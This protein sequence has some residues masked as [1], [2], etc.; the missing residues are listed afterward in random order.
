MAGV[1][2]ML[3][4]TLGENRF[5]VLSA[6]A[7]QVEPVSGRAI[8]G[9]L[10]VSPTTASDHLSLLEAAGLVR[11]STVGRAKLWGLD[12]DCDLVRAWLREAGGEVAS[13]A[14]S[15]GAGVTFERKVVADYLGRL[16]AGDTAAGLGSSRVVVSVALQQAPEFTVDD[17]VVR[18]ALE[19]EAE[20]S[21]VLALAARRTPLLQT[22]N[23]KSQKLFKGLV[24]QL[25]LAEPDGPELRLGLAV[26]GAQEHTE[27][28]KV[29]VGAAAGQSGATGFFTLVRTAG[30][31][32][33]EVQ[34]RLKQIEGLVEKALVDLGQQN[35]PTD[36]V[37]Q[38]TWE[39][40]RRLVVLSP[41]M[42]GPDDS[43]WAALPRVLRPFSTQGTLY[44]GTL[45]RDRLLTLAD[46][47]AP[48]AALVDV[49]M[50]RRRVHELL[51]SEAGRHAAGWRALELLAEQARDAVGD[52][53]VSVDR[54]RRVRLDRSD[55]VEALT[56]SA[57]GSAG[58]VLH[59]ESGV[60]KSAVALRLV[61]A[62][63]KDAG[64]AAAEGG[65][66]VQAAAV[67]VVC[68][69]LRHLPGT[70]LEFEAL[71]GVPLKGL[72]AE[73]SA[74]T[75]L[76][77]VDGADAVGEGRQ[78]LLTYVVNAAVTADVHVVAVT[79]SDVKQLVVD[80]LTGSVG[81]G[82]VEVAVPP[83][84]DAQVDVVVAEL[85]E[86]EAMAANP[87]SRELLRRPVL[88]DLL[89]R[90]GVEGVP[91]SDFDAMEQVWAGLVR[92]R[93]AS[94]R[95][96]PGA[97]NLVML[98]LAR[99]VLDGR[100]QLDAA[101]T[102]DPD[103]VEGLR[104]DGLLRTPQDNPYRPAPEF[105][106][107]ELRRYAVA[108]LLLA[109]DVIK[110]LVDAGV[111]RWALG[112]ARLACQAMLVAG[113]TPG[114]PAAGRFMRWQGRFN[115]LVGAG[116]GERWADVPGEALLTLGDPRA[117]LRDAWPQLRADD[118]A[119]VQRLVRLVDQRLRDESKFVR[120]APVE[121]L[122]ESLLEDETPWAS[123]KPE[124]TLLMDWLRSLATSQTPSGY[125]LREQLRGLLVD[126]CAVADE[127]LRVADEEREAERA[128][129]AAAMTD[130]E[131]AEREARFKK[132]PRSLFQEIGYPRGRPRRERPAISREIT[133]ETVVELFALLGA[134]LGADGEALLRRVAE[135][136]PEDLKPAMEGVTCGHALGRYRQGFLTEMVLAYYLDEE[137]D[138]QGGHINDEGVRDHNF[139]G[140]GVPH[141]ASWRGP[142]M[143]LFEND[144]VGGI[145]ALNR[146]LNHAAL[147]RART[148]AS[149]YGYYGPVEDS[150]LDQ[151]RTELTITG[152]PHAYVGDG[153]VW[154][155]YRGT[156]VGPYPCMSALQALER[157]CDHIIGLG[158]PL[159]RLVSMLLDGCDNVAMVALVVGLLVRHLDK[160]GKLLDRFLAEPDVWH[161]EF[162]RIT[163]DHGFF[164]A[165]SDGIVHAE[166]QQW[167]LREAAMSLV[168][169]AGP[170]RAEELRS[171]G[172]QLVDR[173]RQRI[174]Q[175]GDAV[176]AQAANMELN[177]VRG[178]AS[179]LDRATYSTTETDEGWVI[180]SN[181]PA[182]V[183][184][185]LSEGLGWVRRSQEAMRLT[186]RYHVN[187]EDRTAE[188]VTTEA[189]VADLD[190]AAALM[191][192]PQGLDE[193]DVDGVAAVALVALEEH[194]GHGL[195]L[196]DASVKIAAD[197]VLGIGE[198]DPP[199]RDHD[200]EE[201]YF[202][203]GA[204]RSAAR[205]LPLLLTPAADHV[206]RV[207]DGADGTAAYTRIEAALAALAASNVIQ[208]RLFIARGLDHVWAAPCTNDAACVHQTAL[209][210]ATDMM[211][212]CV[213]GPWS[214]E[215]QEHS[216]EVL[217]D[218][219]VDTLPA[220]AGEDIY[221]SRLDPAIRALGQAA[222]TDTCVAAE[223]SA[224]LGVL[225][226]AQR[227]ALLA[228]DRDTD[229]RGTHALA[230]ARALLTVNDDAAILAHVDAYVDNPAG[231]HHTLS[232]ISA[233]AEEGPRRA[234][235]AHRI[236]PTIVEH[237][238]DAHDSGH[239]PF[240]RDDRDWTM[241]ALL[242]A[243]AGEGSYL[244]AEHAG[245]PIAWWDPAAAHTTVER[246]LG[247]AAGKPK[248]V[249]RLVRF[250]AS[251]LPADEQVRVGLPWVWRAVLADPA[252]VANRCYTVAPWLIEIRTA[253]QAAGALNSWQRTVDALVVAGDSRLAPYS[254]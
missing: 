245:K 15:G 38:W 166:R 99:Q 37:E 66:D 1:A 110:R 231:L 105:A 143:A 83:L 145:A 125:A 50:V 22:S 100:D 150:D 199:L 96:T 207:V 6:V 49:S 59:G 188:P 84:T 51:D 209:R 136:A 3:R 46:E 173:F 70:V 169:A 35:P 82:V 81:Q 252:A 41:R 28:L 221:V 16:L 117:V 203:Q 31:F 24:Q 127:R 34:G 213:F 244:H 68:M 45:L 215:R 202:S 158:M 191:D 111:P 73:M 63:G 248:C 85:S 103:A 90:G 154:N 183:T 10:K 224:L 40:L 21:L 179:G 77:V 76:L 92:R 123:S 52:E 25:M 146:I 13:P 230:S 97:R 87:S 58:V 197:I 219:V 128:A 141:A 187:R 2:E 7:G 226:D 93:E 189:L 26:S 198:N 109:E 126:F 185:V 210:I 19:G 168:L 175:L 72:L 201:S 94:D 132:L 192:D 142:F 80:T 205:A 9:E 211:R 193:M 155:W 5:A 54:V 138:G 53:I 234:D 124:R 227:R 139:W 144:P 55:V 104:K 27:Q 119:G 239:T 60:G 238:L 214:M 18:A 91:V 17:V 36:V 29:L 78:E 61:T 56:T 135:A 220:V 218:P 116:H 4:S 253:A 251:S 113:D 177:T 114:N 200:I 75:R 181:P 159:E 47:W 102:L 232:A 162:N 157:V 23:V 178:W 165:S 88:V 151:F 48:V 186:L 152:V 89:V 243:F 8:A 79:A 240:H 247:V 115:E 233:A 133:D 182:E 190:A 65:A 246:W 241:A 71:L 229:L 140:I 57:V 160:A 74:P 131:R 149:G 250:I 64:E 86:L 148:M 170:E 196:P 206:R 242:P 44:G 176:P 180:E 120:V 42:E 237:V 121:P 129:R 32:N 106:H 161:F 167:S 137:Q 14:S 33:T 12:M 171:V 174:E 254:E 30:K 172:R 69:N 20:P 43:D 225:I 212:E 118:G 222:A 101:V 134:D 122:I 208:T 204:D 112:A 153:N 236:W 11:S 184:A 67:Q 39:L 216:I 156:G 107:D 98:Q 194:L 95:G 164:R 249:D 223:A 228:Q 217:A 62:T 163:H 130:E 108:R 147:V 195:P 235:T